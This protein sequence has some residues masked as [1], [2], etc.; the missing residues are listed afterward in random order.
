MT[1]HL[2]IRVSFQTR[3]IVSACF[4]FR[5]EIFS[6]F[7]SGRFFHFHRHPFFT[8][9]GCKCDMFQRIVTYNMLFIIYIYI[10]IY[11]IYIY[12]TLPFECSYRATYMYTSYMY[13]RYAIAYT[14][15]VY[16]YALDT[17]NLVVGIIS[18][19]VFTVLSRFSINHSI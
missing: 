11:I 3:L 10:Y 16:K 8:S 1:N 17:H 6:I 2:G 14:I 19:I 12:N 15:Y 4:S 18:T 13:T 9:T 5:R 7:L